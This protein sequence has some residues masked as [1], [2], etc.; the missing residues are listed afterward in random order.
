MKHVRVA[1]RGCQDRPSL[2]AMAESIKG[3]QPAALA[4][5]GSPL[6]S[7]TCRRAAK[8]SCTKCTAL[9]DTGCA[10]NALFC[11][12]AGTF[13]NHREAWFYQGRSFRS[14]IIYSKSWSWYRP[15][16][17][18]WQRGPGGV[19][20]NCRSQSTRVFKTMTSR[21]G[22][23]VPA[24]WPKCC[25]RVDL[26]QESESWVAAYSSFFKDFFGAEI[27]CHVLFHR[28]E[29]NHSNHSCSI[30]MTW[31]DMPWPSWLEASIYH[32]NSSVLSIYNI[33]PEQ[34]V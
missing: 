12:F 26:A 23:V 6:L 33:H 21:N 27:P 22:K 13:W 18:W 24:F 3:V 31:H 17:K 7:R 15:G 1:H 9:N 11:Y 4:Q 5:L 8:S 2:S 34:L 14:T 19:G 20:E 29:F 16:K 10:R 25:K 32:L 30:A 28:Y